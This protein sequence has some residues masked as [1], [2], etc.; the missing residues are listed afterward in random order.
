[1]QRERIAHYARLAGLELG[2]DTQIEVTGDDPVLPSPFHLGEGAAT[3]LALVGQEASRIWQARAATRRRSGSMSGAQGG[4]V[5]K[6]RA[7]EGGR[8][9][10]TAGAP[11][12]GRHRHL[13][14]RRRAVHPPARQLRA[15][16]G[17]PRGAGPG[18]RCDGRGRGRGVRMKRGAFELEDALAA[19]GLC[20][21]VCRTQAEEWAARPQGALLA[22]KPWWRSSAS[23][24]GRW[25]RC[26]RRNGR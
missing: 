16:R 8:R 23:A 6:L 1:M 11:G 5:A 25:Y 24:M 21:A 12:H 13:G 9:G 17:D 4:I 2:N 26:T 10:R 20:C 14:V 7:P 19:K 15:H 22:T 3:A 18:A